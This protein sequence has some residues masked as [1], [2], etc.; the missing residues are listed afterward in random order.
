MLSL[1]LACMLLCGSCYALTPFAA[2]VLD[3]ISPLNETRPRKL[4][5]PAYYLVNQEKYYYVILLSE[6][7]SLVTCVLIATAADTTYFLLLEHICG[8]QAV[9]W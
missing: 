4:L 7:V 2:P 5:Y 1:S 9:L 8:M 3:I 6:F